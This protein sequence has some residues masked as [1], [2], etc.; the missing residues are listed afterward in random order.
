MWARRTLLVPA[1]LA[2]LLVGAAGDA[3]ASTLVYVCGSDLC[4]SDDRGRTV[5]G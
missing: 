2:A 1:A 4:R 3:A 5:S